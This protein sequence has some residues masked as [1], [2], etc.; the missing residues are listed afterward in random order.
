[1]GVS[2]II[3]LLV[4]A[5]AAVLGVAFFVMSRE[6]AKSVRDSDRGDPRPVHSEVHDDASRRFVGTDDPDDSPPSRAGDRVR[7]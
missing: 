4:I 3:L 1:M 7:R 2:I 5:V 6:T